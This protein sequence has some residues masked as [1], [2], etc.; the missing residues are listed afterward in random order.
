[1]KNEMTRVI[2][3]GTS[4]VGKTTFARSLARV[5]GF[6]HVEMDALYWQPNWIP[7]ASDEF[8]ALIAQAI[9]Q[10]HWVTDGNYSVVRDL[11]WSR[12]TTVIWLNYVFPLVLWRALIRT[13]RRVLT[14]EELYSGNRESLRMALFSRESI[15]WWVL[16]SFHRRRK[17]YR[18]FFSTRPSSQLVY[19]ELRNPSEAR[20]FLAG[21]DTTVQTS[22]GVKQQWSDAGSSP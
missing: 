11:V 14:Q 21:L 5:L 1:M 8:R 16:T 22:S 3:I 2:V 20:H 18:E 17:Q 15:L 19:V 12:A 6:P 9:A 13:A 7:R 4:C 10:D